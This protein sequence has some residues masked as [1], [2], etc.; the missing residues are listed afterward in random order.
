ML[1]HRCPNLEDLLLSMILSH[2]TTLFKCGSWTKLRR[3]TLRGSPLLNHMPVAERETIIADF[4]QRQPNLESLM[5]SAEFSSLPLPDSSLQRLR[6]VSL[7]HHTT[8]KPSFFL[9]RLSNLVHLD[10]NA[11]YFS[12]VVNMPG[13]ETLQITSSYE[14]SISASDLMNFMKNAP[15]LRKIHL[16]GSLSLMDIV[17]L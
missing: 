17:S 16:L 8:S 5:S 12:C 15:N 1:I 11:R 14:C 6:S 4:F 9:S 13:L 3:L 2:C 10:T 7:I